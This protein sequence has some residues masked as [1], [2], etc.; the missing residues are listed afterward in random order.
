MFCF[1][2]L[3]NSYVRRQACEHTVGNEAAK[4]V[5]AGALSLDKYCCMDAQIGSWNGDCPFFRWPIIPKPLMV[6]EISHW[7]ESPFVQRPVM[8]KANRITGSE[9]M[10]GHLYF[11]HY[12]SIRVANI[13]HFPYL[14]NWL[15]IDNTFTLWRSHFVVPC[16]PIILSFLIQQMALPDKTMS[17]EA[18]LLPISTVN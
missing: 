16:L 8:L 9:K 14:I 15:I 11:S 3:V 12:V 7:T 10:A 2:L 13:V 4:S 17:N 1:C 5:A 18:L 6:R